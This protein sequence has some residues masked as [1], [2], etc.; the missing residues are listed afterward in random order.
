MV[1]QRPGARLVCLNRACRPALAELD[2]RLGVRLLQRTT[3]KLS[4]TEVGEIYLRHRSAMRDEAPAALRGRRPADA[5]ACRGGGN[6]RQFSTRQHEHGRVASPRVGAVLAG[7][8]PKP[9]MTHAVFPPRRGQ[10]PA[11]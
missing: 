6:R 3:R 8:A 5:Q 11:V 10:V 9:D 4:L 2:A 1:L 7:W